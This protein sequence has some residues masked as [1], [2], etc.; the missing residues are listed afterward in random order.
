M[1]RPLSEGYYPFLTEPTS[2]F[3]KDQNGLHQSAYYNLYLLYL[4]ARPLKKQVNIEKWPQSADE[5]VTLS[6]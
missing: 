5:K 2:R 3:Q 1:D 6:I 4:N